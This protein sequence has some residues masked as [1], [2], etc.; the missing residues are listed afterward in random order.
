M[1]N[2]EKMEV[3]SP[4]NKKEA[5]NRIFRQL[6]GKLV[7]ESSLLLP[8]TNPVNPKEEF[9]IISSIEKNE[10]SLYAG[11]Y[12]NDKALG[13]IRCLV[14]IYDELAKDKPDKEFIE[15]TVEQLKEYL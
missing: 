8:K 3:S 10:V 11:N 14:A 7:K 5:Q 15:E 1:E 6:V 9:D 2:I 4:E 12:M 13:A